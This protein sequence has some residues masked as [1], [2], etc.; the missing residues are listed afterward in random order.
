M[1]ALTEFVNMN[2][3]WDIKKFL[4]SEN[5]GLQK[6]INIRLAH[7]Q[8]FFQLQSNRFP[9]ESLSSK[10]DVKL[11]SENFEKRLEELRERFGLNQ[12]DKD[13]VEPSSSELES[14]D[15]PQELLKTSPTRKPGM[16]PDRIAEFRKRLTNLKKSH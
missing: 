3:S 16:S 14:F 15:K 8:F 1:V 6:Y 9:G 2:P 10:T 12:T 4:K 13:A 5:K 7:G 11:D